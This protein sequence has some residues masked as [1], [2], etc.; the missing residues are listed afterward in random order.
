[1]NMSATRLSMRS[2]WWLPV[3]ALATLAVCGLNEVAYQQ[4]RQAIDSLKSHADA[5]GRIQRLLRVVID[6]ETG[7]R[8][9][10]LTGRQDY[11]KPYVHSATDSREQLGWLSAYYRKDPEVTQ[12]VRDIRQATE[13]KLSELSTSIVMYEQ[14]R[15]QTWHE[16]IMTDLGKE[17]MENVRALSQRLL[18]IEAQRSSHDQDAINRRL[19]IG[20]WGVPVATLLSLG[21]LALFLRQNSKLRAFERLHAMEMK[22]ERD[23]FEHEVV[24]RTADLTQLAR[25]LQT[26]SEHE[27]SR[28]SRELHDELGSLMTAAKL[29]A[30]RLRRSLG[31]PTA[32]VEDRL[33]HLNEAINN[34]IELKRR[35]IEDLRPSSLS[36]LGL[37]PAL[38]IQALEF[39]RRSDIKVTSRF[40]SVALT[41]SAQITVYRLFQEALTNLVKYAGATEVDMCVLAQEGRALV[42]VTDNGQG[43]DPAVRRG[44]AHGLMG[45]RYRVEAEGGAL[46][47]RSRPGAGTRIE[48][49]IPFA[50]QV[51]V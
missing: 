25:H 50:N 2:K 31:T 46:T 7:Q 36:H 51:Q 13:T 18:A 23:Q 28:L 43:F 19:L 1:M 42:S 10:L 8:G 3:A 27:R 35:I 30:A 14:G 12:L 21:G 9:Y 26:A 34:G 15:H 47:V 16:L 29:D 11:L 37:V 20:R 48:A 45:M 6:A 49:W 38:E 5:T 41:E 44:S 22:Q 32:E 33:K 40:E 4:S 17:S 39:A 24:R